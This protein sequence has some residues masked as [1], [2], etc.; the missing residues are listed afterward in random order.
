MKC[1]DIFKAAASLAGLYFLAYSFFPRQNQVSNPSYN[2]YFV[3]GSKYTLV[4]M[5]QIHKKPVHRSET[6]EEK[7]RTIKDQNEICHILQG[8]IKRGA[9]NIYDGGL[10]DFI[11]D[12][13][14][15]NMV[16]FILG[17]DYPLFFLF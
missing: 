10:S 6:K 8:F 13:Y 4:H 2:N 16:Y 9:T 17:F 3:P 12:E 1:P 11:K 14:L 15:G 5:R 7:K